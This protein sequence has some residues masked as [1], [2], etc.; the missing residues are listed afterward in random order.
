[1]SMRLVG[2][3]W[4][5]ETLTLVRIPFFAI[6][7]LLFPGL[8][9]LLFGV[10]YARQ[11]GAAEVLMAS[12]A[13][14]GVIGVTLFQFGV[15]IAEDRKSPWEDFLHILPVAPSV[16]FTARIL[17]ALL[18]ALIAVVVVIALGL[19]FTP[20][21]LSMDEWVKLLFALLVGSIPF[22]LIGIT[23]GYWLHP[24]AALPIANILNLLMA[25]AGGLWFPPQSLP[26]PVVHISV[27][28]PMWHYREVIWSAVLN[29]PWPLV[30][31]L[32][33]LGYAV[34]FGALALWGYR[35]D[36]GQRYA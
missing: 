5:A 14:Y 24:K 35:R 23:L 21:R 12:F 18:F 13:G 16:R 11:P 30:S 8:L 7:T 6:P 28:L 17:S 2:A 29:Q 15:G 34:V 3:H 19:L 33:L 27:Y 36:Q 22:V 4:K 1:M 20:A 25:Y 26:G 10:P 32:W 31:W 9:F